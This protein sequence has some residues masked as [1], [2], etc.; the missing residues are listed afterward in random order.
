MTLWPSRTE[1]AAG[2]RRP[3]RVSIRV[4]LPAP[5]GPTRTTCS[6]R[7]TSSPG[8]G[9]QGPARHLDR[10]AHQLD[11]DP[12]GALGLDEGE[13]QV[14]AVALLGLDPVA[15]DLVDLLQ[16]RLR[17]PRLGRLV[18]EA[19]DE[20]LHA[21]DL[22]LLA[23]DRLAAGDLAR[24]LL[25]APGVPGPGE[26]ARPLRLQL[27]H[28]GADRL[29]E[30]AVVGD[31]DDGGVEVAQVALQPLQR[32]DVEVV[33]RLVEQQQ[34]GPGRQRPR[35]RGA[36]QLAAGEGRERALGLLA[37]EAE[38]AQ[39]GEDAVAPAVAAAV[40]EPLLGG[41]VGVQRLLAGFA[42]RHRRL[43]P[44]QL[45]LGLEHLGAAGEDVLAERDL[46]FAR[47]ALVVQGDPGAALQD[48][49]A[50]VR[51]ELARQHAQQGRLAGAVAAGERH[52]LAR[53]EL[54]GD[55]FEQQLAA[56]VD[57]EGGCGRDCHR[58][59][60]YETG[61]VALCDQGDDAAGDHQDAE[62][63]VRRGS[64]RLRPRSL[65]FSLKRSI[66]FGVQSG[67]KV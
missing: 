55:V 65:S 58:R 64:P 21:L 29:E 32:G 12:A 43:Q 2:S 31:E 41:G 36:G 26:E 66:A 60:R 63:C 17:L 20:A 27:Q 15:L 48:E 35:Q 23:L 62:S 19:L 37:A 14:A 6:P 28:R 24:R 44:L 18:A 38:A 9:E 53:L 50:G 61:P 5:L 34:V 10:R 49:A 40:L 56:H 1:P 4:V 59:L 3:A 16:P 33:G 45:R 30:P 57:V 25:L 47:R 11:H 22:G 46:G 67:A 8:V 42:G 7:S 51:G 52:P 39:H 13:A 54:E